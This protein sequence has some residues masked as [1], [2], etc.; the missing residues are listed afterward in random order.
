MG[1]PT[2]TIGFC[3]GLRIRFLKYGWIRIWSEHLNLKSLK[4]P[5]IYWPKLYN[6]V[7]S[8]SSHLS[9]KLHACSTNFFF[10]SGPCEDELFENSSKLHLIFW[11]E[12]NNDQ[13]SFLLRYTFCFLLNKCIWF[14]LIIYQLHWLLWIEKK[15]KAAFYWTKIR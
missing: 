15:V 2:M 7:A 8:L 12:L 1:F 4:N 14:D 11:G 6:T 9:T 13:S 10:N 3:A 5:S